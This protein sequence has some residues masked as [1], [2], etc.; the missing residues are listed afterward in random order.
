[1]QTKS[2]ACALSRE[3]LGH[4]NYLYGV[5]AQPLGSWEGFYMPQRPT[6]NFA[7]RYQLAFVVYALASMSQRTPAYHAPYAEAIQA[8]IEKMLH[9]D[10]WGYWRAASPSPQEA[11]TSSHVNSGHVAVLLQPH[12][13]AVAGAS[14]DPIVRDNLQYSGHLST[15]LGLYEKVSG[16]NRYDH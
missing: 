1:M 3:S 2:E 13:R 8:A 10:S 9:V 6:M 11:A 5:L 4:L 16:D 7:L 15:M 14:S 12:Q